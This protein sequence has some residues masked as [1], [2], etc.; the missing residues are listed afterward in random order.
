MGDNEYNPEQI[1]SKFEVMEPPVFVSKIPLYLTEKLEP[2]ELYIVTSVSLMEQRV[3]NNTQNIKKLSE[4]VIDFD[5]FKQFSIKLYSKFL[6]KWT[7][8]YGAAA[9]LLAYGP[10]SNGLLRHGTDL[11]R[12]LWR[13]R[14][15]SRWPKSPLRRRMPTRCEAG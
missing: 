10:S 4:A 12:R 5:K 6:S 9:W 1:E 2:K 15:K 11:P 13:S 3:E 8:I 7:L 14:P